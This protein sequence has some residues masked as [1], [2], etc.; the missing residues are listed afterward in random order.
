MAGVDKS[1]EGTAVP[2]PASV[3]YLTEPTLGFDCLDSVN[4]GKESKAGLQRVKS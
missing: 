2:M 1:F 4:L 3:G